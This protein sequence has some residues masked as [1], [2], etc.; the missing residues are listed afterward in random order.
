MLEGRKVSTRERVLL[1][2][3]GSIAIGDRYN[4]AIRFEEGMLN[5]SD[6]TTPPGE[7]I[8]GFTIQMS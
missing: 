8:E 7:L 3:L 4:G 5:V 1:K 6:H 2:T